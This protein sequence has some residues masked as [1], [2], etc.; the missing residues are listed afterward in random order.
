MYVTVAFEL[1]VDACC[2]AALRAS[3]AE[4]VRISA[5]LALWLPY[6]SQGTIGQG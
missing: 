1:I 2:R 4:L 6:A 5:S 3:F